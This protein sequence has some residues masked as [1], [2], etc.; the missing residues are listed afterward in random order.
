MG[1]RR[2]LAD[3]SQ[4][5]SGAED[6][7]GSGPDLGIPLTR[8]GLAKTFY[9]SKNTALRFQS[10]AHPAPDVHGTSAF[11]KSSYFSI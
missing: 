3:K 7:H 11:K 9:R 4:S 5:S 6:G 10:N 8:D 2:H 1:I